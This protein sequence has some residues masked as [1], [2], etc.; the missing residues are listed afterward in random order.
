[1]IVAG[2]FVPAAAASQLIDRN[3][4]HVTLSVNGDGR[5]LVSY[6]VGASAKRVLAWGALNANPPSQSR[7]Q[8]AFH[9]NYRAGTFAGGCQPYDGPPLAW[10][11]AAC[12]APDGSYWALQSWQRGLRDYGG[13]SAP[14]ELRLSHWTGDVPTLYVQLDWSYHRFVHLWGSYTYNGQGVYGFRSTSTGSPLDSYGRNLYVDT[15]DSGFGSGW[16]RANSFLTHAPKGAFCF[17]FYPHAGRSSA[18]AKL[19]ATIIG[20]GVAPDVMWQG[21]S[22]GPYNAA[23]DAQQNQMQR[24]LFGASKACKIN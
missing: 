19:R 13:T 1:V 20:P 18:G 10:L 4:S 14:W 8:V 3:A 21:A 17:G 7:A 16:R 22:P 9:L 6:H 23:V 11:V 5:A 12:K 15:F 24:S 2:S